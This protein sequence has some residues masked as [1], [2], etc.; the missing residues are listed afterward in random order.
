[1]I[2]P[3]DHVIFEETM[4]E[5]MKGLSDWVEKESIQINLPSTATPAMVAQVVYDE[6][7]YCEVI[8]KTPIG[9]LLYA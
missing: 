7:Y 2:A 3:A 5:S 9:K 1:M 6:I 8:V 4:N